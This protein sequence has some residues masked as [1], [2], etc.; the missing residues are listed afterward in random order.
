MAR[1]FRTMVP[2]TPTTPPAD[3][4]PPSAVM[5]PSQDPRTRTVSLR[6]NRAAVDQGLD[7]VADGL[8]GDGAGHADADSARAA[9]RKGLDRPGPDGLDRNAPIGSTDRTVEH[10][11]LDRIGNQVV[12]HSCADTAANADRH[13]TGSGLDRRRIGSME[14]NAACVHCRV[15]NEGLCS[16]SSPRWRPA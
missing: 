8:D 2:P 13:L 15:L 7:R 1:V 3:M 10:A 9:R 16:R 4:A 5:S 6:R 14:S 12:G 11:S